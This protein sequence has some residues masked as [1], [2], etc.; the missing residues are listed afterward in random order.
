MLT[1]TGYSFL[2]SRLRRRSLSRLLSFLMAGASILLLLAGTGCSHRAPA[3]T[4]PA[5][6]SAPPPPAPEPPSTNASVA[7]PAL[8]VELVP[9]HVA[10]GDSAVMT[11]Q[12]QNAS[13][14]TIDN[15]IGAVDPSGKI[16][17]FPD[18]TTTYQ[19]VASGPGGTTRKSVTVEVATGAGGEVVSENLA[20]LSQAERFD[21]FVKPVFF[22]FDSAELTDEAKLTLD[23]NVR[24]LQQPE[25]LNLN[26][27]IEGHS[28]ERG[29]AEYNLA[30]ADKRAQV[31]KSY[32]VSKGMNPLRI[33]TVSLGEEKP[34][35]SRHDE[36]AWALNRRAQFELL[37]QP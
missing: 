7:K 37:T 9:T 36:A 35:D 13:Q 3:V 5:R 14:V 19:L 11:W 29:T 23:G 20:G 27:I 22:S 26:F 12:S 2:K 15:G 21:Y 31:V 33:S 16:K 34:F 24:W 32:L 1:K 30:L 4:P 10:K 25:N 8:D 18:A 6:T 17:L 28:D